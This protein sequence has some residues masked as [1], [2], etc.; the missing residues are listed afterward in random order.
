MMLMANFRA[1]ERETPTD[2]RPIAVI[3]PPMKGGIGVQSP[4]QD[5]VVQAVDSR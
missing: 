1:I 5:H 2:R 4:N 3:P